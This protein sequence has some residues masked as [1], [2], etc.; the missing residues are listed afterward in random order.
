MGREIPPR[1]C[2]GAG[3]RDS[4]ALSTR[5]G[6]HGAG[7]TDRAPGG[8]D[9]GQCPAWRRPG[10]SEPLHTVA[11]RRNPNSPRRSWNPPSPTCQKEKP[12]RLGEGEG[13]VRGEEASSRSR[14]STDG[15][16]ASRGSELPVTGGV[17]TRLGE[18]RVVVVSGDP[19]AGWELPGKAFSPSSAGGGSPCCDKQPPRPGL[20]RSESHNSRCR[21]LPQPS[22]G[23]GPGR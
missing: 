23:W 16:R 11:E 1:P 7:A 3:R 5:D 9:G 6:N 18:A 13:G 8:V 22:S 12:P 19:S 15:K 10:R 20:D 21:C 17:Q 2:Q 14:A 4:A